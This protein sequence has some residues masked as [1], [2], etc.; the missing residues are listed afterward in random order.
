MYDTFPGICK[1]AHDWKCYVDLLVEG[2]LKQAV[3]AMMQRKDEVEETNRWVKGIL[4]SF[5][6]QMN[7]YDI[8]FFY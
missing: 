5:I 2:E 8:T 6:F 1:V 7:E 4:K 3:I